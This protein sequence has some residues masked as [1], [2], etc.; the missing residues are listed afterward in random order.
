MVFDITKSSVCVG[1]EIGVK[2]IEGIY[3][4]LR[5]AAA[6]LENINHSEPHASNESYE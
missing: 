6:P 2:T 4:R 1:K 5:L 3:N